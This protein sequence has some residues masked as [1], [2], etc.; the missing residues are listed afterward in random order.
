MG[1]RR[2]TNPWA[3]NVD[4]EACLQSVLWKRGPSAK[5]TLSSLPNEAGLSPLY[6]VKKTTLLDYEAMVNDYGAPSKALLVSD[7]RS[8]F[9]QY[10]TWQA[11]HLRAQ[12]PPSAYIMKTY[13]HGSVGR[14]STTATMSM[15]DT[16][17]I[18]NSHVLQVLMFQRGEKG[19]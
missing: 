13:W 18:I 8:N 5:R 19:S 9:C 7:W 10:A 12:G 17:N 2:P 14:R 1:D 6:R 16:V 4:P 11:P 15:N 3:E